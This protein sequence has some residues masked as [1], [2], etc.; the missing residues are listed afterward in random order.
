MNIFIFMIAIWAI[1][2][3][4]QCLCVDRIVELFFRV[5]L[6][7]N[8][9]SRFKII[10]IIFLSVPGFFGFGGEMGVFMFPLSNLFYFPA[11]FFFDPDSGINFI[12][13]FLSFFGPKEQKLFALI[14]FSTWAIPI[15]IIYFLFHGGSKKSNLKTKVTSS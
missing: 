7:S 10:C 14:H 11:T 4:I 3:P 15:L 5:V 9:Y 6:K 2:V 8:K 12:R 13:V 1:A